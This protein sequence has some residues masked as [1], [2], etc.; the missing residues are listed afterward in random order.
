MHIHTP[1]FT[2]TH[3]HTHTH[4][5]TLH[6]H[7]CHCGAHPH[8]QARVW[9]AVTFVAICWQYT[10]ITGEHLNCIEARAKKILIH[11]GECES[12]YGEVG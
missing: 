8:L 9:T 5:F 2:H 3:K 12:A 6:S 7:Y 4:T 1:T 10:H 11:F